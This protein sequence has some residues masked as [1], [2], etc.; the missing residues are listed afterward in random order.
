[1][2][3][4][5]QDLRYAFRQLIRMP[6]FTCTAVISLALGIGATTAMF[7]I[8]YAVLFDPY[9]YFAPDRM[10]H[11]R[12]VDKDGQPRGFGLTAAQ[13]QQIRKSPVIESAFLSD[14]WSLTVTG[15]DLP[16]DVEADYFSSNAFEHFGV[17]VAL[18]RGLQPSDAIDGQD[19]QPVVVLSYKF[20]KRHF[21]GDPSVVGRTMQLVHKN[22]TIVGVA[23]PRFTWDDVDVYVPQKI[24]P[25]AMARATLKA[26]TGRLIWMAASWGKE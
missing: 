22:Y 11:L 12:L 17:P 8:V 7:S 21:N 24:T 23:A 5:L 18:G 13:F 9:P 10:I 20:W 25:V 26:R 16:E 14:N 1:M 15:S 3:T 4:V 19:P 6:G 2:R